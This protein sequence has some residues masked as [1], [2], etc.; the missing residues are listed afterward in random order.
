MGQIHKVIQATDSPNA[1]TAASVV[2]SVAEV[3]RKEFPTG[4]ERMDAIRDFLNTVR[5]AHL[6]EGHFLGLLHVLVGRKI[7]RTDGSVVSTGLTWRQTASYLRQLRFDPQLAREVNVD[8]EAVNIR[9]RDRFWYAVIAQAQ[10]DSPTAV[11]EADK[12]APLLQQHGYIVGPPPPGLTQTPSRPV[13]PP[14]PSPASGSPP[15][16]KTPSAKN[17]PRKKRT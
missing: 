16:G 6:V 14:P 7:T 4:S 8:P 12:L 9:D 11:A 13:T 17:T 2:H 5:Q 1:W 3:T 10:L 15:S